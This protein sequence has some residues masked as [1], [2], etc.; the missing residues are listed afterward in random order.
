MTQ[1]SARILC[2]E[3]EPYL[4]EDLVDELRYLG[5][6]VEEAADGQEGL[7]RALAKPFDLIICDILL[8]QLGGVQL[9][10]TLR[11]SGGRNAATQVVFL[12]AYNDAAMAAEC[13]RIGS[14]AYLLKPVQYKDL[15]IL[16]EKIL[17]Q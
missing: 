4:R 5:H 2:I 8:P 1:I 13:S 6:Q 10:E 15:A 17:H 11:N 12:T 7:D 14:S 9:V 16:I 3:D